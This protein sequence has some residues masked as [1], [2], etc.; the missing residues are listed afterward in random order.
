MIGETLA[1]APIWQERLRQSFP[2]LTDEDILERARRAR[3][4]QERIE[5]T[6]MLAL[7]AGRQVREPILTGLTSS[8]RHSSEAVRHA[9]VLAVGYAQWPALV[10]MLDDIAVRDSSARVRERAE[11]MRGLL[12]ADGK[13]AWSREGEL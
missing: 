6:Y 12:A 3:D 5:A 11:S 4:D 7:I 13:A 9:A 2:I 1:A 10:D 8:L